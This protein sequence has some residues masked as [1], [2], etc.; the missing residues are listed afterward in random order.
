MKLARI[1]LDN[2]Y[3]ALFLFFIVAIFNYIDRSILTVL[4]VPIKAELGLSDTQLGLLTGLGFALFYTLMGLPLARLTDRAVRKYMIAGALATWSL[5]TALSS[6]ATGFG[7][8]LTLRIGVAVGEAGS[9]PGTHSMI[10]DYFPPE[11][12]ASA[13]ALWG[14][15]VPIGTMI[16]IASGGW[17]ATHVG[18]RQ[19]FLIVGVAGMLLAPVVLLTLHEPK[20]GRLD[21]PGLTNAAL[22]S[23]GE[24]M[25]LLWRLKAFRYLSIGG[26]THVFAQ[27]A[28]QS[29]AAPFYTRVHGMA[30]GEAALYVALLNGL[31]GGVGILA[32]GWLSERW[33]RRDPAGYLLVPGIASLIAAPTVIAQLLAPTQQISLMIGVIPAIAVACYVA[34]VTAVSQSL[35]PPQMRALTAAMLILTINLVGIGLGPSVTGAVSDALLPHLPQPGASLRYALCLATAAE[36][37]SVFFFFKAAGHL[38]REAAARAR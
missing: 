26:A 15:A 33:G 34:P 27:A 22:P 35:V 11:R 10:S 30:I 29:W 7:S 21:P 8:L 23:M 4:Q 17:L 38:R 24:A 32:G 14:L 12:R 9:V 18:W 16:G 5:M 36:L 37:I 31:F 25:R 2:R 20:R 19:A 1:G 6:L 28:M 13:I 3:Y